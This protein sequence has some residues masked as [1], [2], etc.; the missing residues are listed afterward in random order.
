MIPSKQINEFLIDQILTYGVRSYDDLTR[1]NKQELT[2]HILNSCEKHEKF[3][4]LTEHAN[5]DHTITLLKAALISDTNNLHLLE[6]IKATACNYYK[7]FINETIE[8]IINDPYNPELHVFIYSKQLADDFHPIS[9][10]DPAY[11]ERTCNY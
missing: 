1:E 2:A 5:S 3:E 7:N 8:E 4:C 11:F 6:H 9:R 10:N